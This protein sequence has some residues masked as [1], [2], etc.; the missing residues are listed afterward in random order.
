HRSDDRA[1]APDARLIERERTEALR[2][3]LERISSEAAA[4]VRAR[5]GGEDYREACRRLELTP[6]RAYT[7]FHRAKEQLQA[8]LERVL[9]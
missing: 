4:L 2:R 5:L 1:G 3:C 7:L 8:C 9:A 6:E